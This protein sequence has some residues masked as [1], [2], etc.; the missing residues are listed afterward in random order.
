MHARAGPEVMLGRREA[1]RAVRAADEVED[2]EDEAAV[3]ERIR[4]LRVRM[5]VVIVVSTRQW[6]RICQRQ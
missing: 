6:Y 1:S 3:G 2:E 4:S 5:V